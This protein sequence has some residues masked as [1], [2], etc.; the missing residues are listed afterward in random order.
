MSCSTR[1]WLEG[2]SALWAYRVAFN[3]VFRMPSRVGG[4]GPQVRLER[5]VARVAKLRSGGDVSAQ[6][7]RWFLQ[8]GQVESRRDP[9]DGQVSLVVDFMIPQLRRGAGAFIVMVTGHPYLRS[10]LCLLLTMS[11]YFIIASVVLLVRCA[12]C[13][14]PL[15]KVGLAPSYLRLVGRMTADPPMLVSGQ[16]QSCRVGHVVSPVVRRRR[17][18]ATRSTFVISFP[19]PPPLIWVPKM[20]SCNEPSGC[21]DLPPRIPSRAVDSRD[22][23]IGQELES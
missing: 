7:D 3:L 13:L 6:V 17:D 12:A 22:D 9:S 20:R 21:S 18:V 4:K 14:L 23:P 10:L 5:S 2:D 8:E 16:A 11:S 19:P 1:H 15:G